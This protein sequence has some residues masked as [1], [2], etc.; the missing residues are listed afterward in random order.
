M[1]LP[2][3]VDGYSGYKLNERPR[4]FELDSRY[5]RIYALEAEWRSP[6]GHYF[7]VRAQGERLVLRYDERGGPILKLCVSLA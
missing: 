2:I 7:K 6:S 5:Y 1:S 4:G 3:H